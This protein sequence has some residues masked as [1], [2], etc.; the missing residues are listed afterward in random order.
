MSPNLLTLLP[1][2]VLTVVAV[3]I[4][5]IEPTLGAG[6]SRKPLGWLAIFGTALAAFAATV[7]LKW[8]NDHGT[9]TGFYGTVQIDAFS[10]F[11]HLL[12][13]VIVLV[14]LLASFDYFEGPVS[15][16]GEYY[17]LALFGATG[18]MLM[19]CS[20][21]LLMVF[22]GLEISSIS[23][24][25]LAGFRKGRATASE[26]A[27]KYFLLGSFATSFFLYGI[28]LCFGATGSTSIAAI[29][30]GLA[31]TA[32]PLLGWLAVA[33]VLIGLGFK[34]SAAPFHVWTPDVY[35]GA[36][37]PVVGMMSTAPKAAA[38]AVLLRFLFNATPMYRDH[39]VLLIA[40]L[41]VLSMTIGNLGALLQS[42]VKRLLAYSSIANA[43]YQLVAFTSTPREAVSS[44]C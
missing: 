20:V 39:W 33:M 38:F 9:L 12:I 27:L 40:I 6:T 29:A 3:L 13:A 19:T 31:T 11:F 5:L 17:A 25:I 44:A 28:A 35:Q 24:Y 37:A 43:G 36:P 8:V 4:M 22:I 23:T 2:L 14:V 32:T 42:D 18:M 26:A 16:A 1:E 7:Q 34:V 30:A 41:A 15:H 10:V 21:E